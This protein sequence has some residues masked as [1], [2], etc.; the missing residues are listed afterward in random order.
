MTLN[1]KQILTY[2]SSIAY[3]HEQINSFGVGDLTQLIN[4]VTTKQEPHYTRMYVVP[5][6]VEFNQ[7]HIHF[8]FNVIIADQIEDDL[9]NQREVM[10]DTLAIAMDVWTVFWQS[11]TQE[12]G[13]FSQI[14]VGDWDAQCQPFLERFQT[15]LGGWTLNIKMSAPFDYNSCDLPISPNYNFPQDESFSSYEQIVLDWEQFAAAHEQVRSFGYGDITQLIDDNI[16][17]QT[18]LFPRLYFQPETTRFSPNHMHITWRVIIC[19]IVDDDL[20]NQQDV[21]SDTL[22]IAK[23]LYAKAYLSDYDIE[24]DANL[25]P[26]FQETQTVLAGWTYTMNVQQKFD[27]NRCTLPIRP[28]VNYTWE[29]MVM[30]WKEVE[31]KWKNV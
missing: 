14:I 15:V 17:K 23:D 10:S 29:E 4:D 16:T 26:W 18:P 20:S 24:W 28:F 31:N 6:V 8:N 5:E 12:Y 21:W 3:H 2:F 30:L 9:S 1:Y 7:N 27:Y 11:Y 19:D 22:E 13:D 25:E